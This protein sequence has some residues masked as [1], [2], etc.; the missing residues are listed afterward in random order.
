ML[1]ATTRLS[2]PFQLHQDR[3]FRAGNLEA[4]T[5][6]LDSLATNLASA[7]L[8]EARLSGAESH[9]VIFGG[10]S[11]KG[12]LGLDE[13]IFGGPWTID[14]RTLAMNPDLP[15]RFLR[16]CGLPDDLI[17]YLPDLVGRPLEFQSCFISHSTIDKEFVDRLYADLQNAGVRCYYAPN[18]LEPGD[19]LRS[20]LHK[21][22]Q[23]RDRTLLAL[24]ENS[25]G[26]KW[27]EEEILKA[28]KREREQTER[29]LFPISIVPFELIKAWRCPDDDSGEDLA[30][31]VRRFYIPDFSNWDVDA[32]SYKRELGKLLRALRREPEMADQAEDTGKD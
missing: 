18:D 7:N 27:V 13:C 11:L 19:H 16:G 25:I 5:Q 24:S 15:L 9:E 21:A 20:Q 1:L 22:I 30:R 3:I 14:F 29:V 12:A 10:T 32:E 28:R 4:Q 26:S 6:D 17:E 31:E 23:L 2:G 8:T